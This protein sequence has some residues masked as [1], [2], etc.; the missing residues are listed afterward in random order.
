VPDPLMEG[1]SEEMMLAW[2]PF[3]AMLTLAIGGGGAAEAGA[4]GMAATVVAAT[5]IEVSM[6]RDRDMVLPRVRISLGRCGV[7]LSRP[8]RGWLSNENSGP[9]GPLF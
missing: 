5:A 8:D 3:E 2:A 6:W 9:G 4:A 1:S 7:T